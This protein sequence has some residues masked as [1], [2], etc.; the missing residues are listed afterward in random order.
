[1]LIPFSKDPIVRVG[2]LV[3]WALA[4]AACSTDTNSMGSV[5]RQDA[6]P[7]TDAPPS[8]RDAAKPL[9]SAVVVDT[10]RPLDSAVA[11]DAAR[12]L[13]SAVAMDTARKMDGLAAVDTAVS[14]D[15]VVAIDAAVVA[16]DT[17]GV[18]CVS[19]SGVYQPGD[20]IPMSSCTTCRCLPDG[21]VG[22]CTGLCT[23]DAGP[24]PRD[25]AGMDTSPSD[26]GG[27]L[28]LCLSTG[29]QV[30]QSLCCGSAG[31]AASFPNSCLTGAC[32]CSPA[33]STLVDTCL[34]PHNGCF[35]PAEGCVG[36]LD[37]CTV[38]MDQ[39]CNDSPVISSIHGRCLTLGRCACLDGFQLLASGKC[40]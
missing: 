23:P 11:V 37:V 17:G 21:S 38:G 36:P 25:T 19:G 27:L 28:A 1:M 16:T 18:T 26:A 24:V 6:S 33:N 12:P 13:D 39:T 30:S 15:G 7:G 35:D 5:G 4:G 3:A 22:Q 32:G 31:S 20:V 34:C 8:Q 14:V 2:V 10:A 9:D 40:S 29:G